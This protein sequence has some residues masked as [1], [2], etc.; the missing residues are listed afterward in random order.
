VSA[1][2]RIAEDEFFSIILAVGIDLEPG[3]FAVGLSAS[4]DSN[5]AQL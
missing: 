2:D 5:Y 4:C 3:P 1:N